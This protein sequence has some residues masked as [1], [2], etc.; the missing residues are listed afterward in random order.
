MGVGGVPAVAVGGGLAVGKRPHPAATQPDRHGWGEQPTGRLA[1]R[2]AGTG[3]VAA[4]VRARV[5][6]PLGTMSRDRRTDVMMSA[7]RK[8]RESPHT[9]Q[10]KRNGSLGTH[11][12]AWPIPSVRPRGAARIGSDTHGTPRAAAAR[13]PPPSGRSLAGLQRP[14]AGTRVVLWARAQ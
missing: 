5:Q 12:H 2:W 13:W 7:W 6:L 10:E 3:R 8:R 1:T 11:N 4:R 9:S 14:S